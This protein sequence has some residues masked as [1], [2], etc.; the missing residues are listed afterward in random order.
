MR[1]WQPGRYF[2]IFAISPLWIAC[3][4]GGSPTSALESSSSITTEIPTIAT[5]AQ[6]PHYSKLS[7]L[8]ISGICNNGYFVYL[9]GSDFSQQIC[10]NSQYSFTV[11]K[12]VDGIYPYMISQ[13]APGKQASNPALLFW[14]RKNSV[15][16]PTIDSPATNPFQSALSTLALSG[17]CETG[18]TVSL[19]GDAV[20]SVECAN[21]RFDFNVTKFVDQSY[22]IIVRQTDPATN[23]AFINFVWNKMA[24]AS[25]PANPQIVVANSQ[26]FAITGGSGTYAGTFIENNSGGTYDDGTRTY[27]AGTV[28]GVTDR[29]RIEDSLGSA[30]EVTVETVPSTPDH[31][32]IPIDSG[33]GQIHP[34][35]Q[36]LPDPFKAVVVDRYGNPVEN[37]EVVF[38]LMTEGAR[39]VGASNRTTNALG[40]VTVQVRLGESATRIIVL[41]KP[42]TGIFLDEAGTGNTSASFEAFPQFANTNKIGLRSTVGNNPVKVL[43]E[44]LD[45]D[46]FQDFAVLNNGEP[47]LGILR[48]KGNGL[49]HSMVRRQPICTGPTDFTIG[50]LNEDG[51]KDFAI[52]CSGSNRIALILTD[53]DGTYLPA[54]YIDVDPMETLPVAILAFDSNADGHVDLVSLSAGGSVASLRLGVGN[55]SFSAP[56][57][58]N[59]G[60]GPSA[61]TIFDINK[62]GRPDL[63]IVNSSDGTIG[64]LRNTGAGFD[65]METFSTGTA[66][67]S[68][69]AA[70][71]NMDTFDDLAVLNNGDNEIGLYI[72]DQFDNFHPAVNLTVVGGPIGLATTDVNHDSIPDLFVTGTEESKMSI[73]LGFGNGTFDPQPTIDLGPNP[74]GLASADFNGDTHSDFVVIA[75]GDQSAH[76]YIGKGDGTLGFQRATGPNPT[77]AAISDLDGDGV[78]DLAVIE[79]GSNSVSILKGNNTGLW[80]PL[81]TLTTNSGPAA[82]VL[83]DVNNDGF[84]DVVVSHQNVSNV[85]VYLNDG[86]GDFDGSTDYTT[87]LQPIGLS[88]SDLNGDGFVELITA[89]SGSNTVS[90]LQNNGDGTF[91]PR[92]DFPVGSQPVA[93]SVADLNNDLALDLVS[94]NQGSSDVSVLIS[95][96]D[97]TFQVSSQ[98]AVGNGANSIV[99]GFFNGDIDVDVAVVNEMEGSVS[100]LMG[101]GDGSLDN[102]SDFWAGNTP[103]SIRM[104]DFNGDNKQD[105]VVANGGSNSFTVMYGTGSG[106]F[107]LT[108]TILSS[109]A[110]DSLQVGDFN[111]DGSVD[112]VTLEALVGS[113]N[114]WM[115]H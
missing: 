23:T 52:A 20:D 5:P 99:T 71:F 95:N 10:Q 93:I 16:Q 112:I 115:G 34:I 60:L 26:V 65:P 66:P 63:A 53:T 46:G 96:G 77:M 83:A 25:N 101:N 80:Q 1:T 113:M 89:N 55:G 38:S 73:L 103:R 18:S 3:H 105:F 75:N 108:E 92:A 13:A 35:G 40:E 86:T 14:I 32:E 68:I 15:T 21:S 58:F 22:N 8:E 62:D 24:L 31:F 41:A 19:E 90:V 106:F 81:D 82:I 9:N 30:I 91:A 12:N 59:V 42:R 104:G 78:S 85:R 39:I 56:T 2:L 74:I 37:F 48:G 114:F 109:N 6:S 84:V 98:F 100:V 4:M 76:V 27:T 57:F 72:N 36:L 54:S 28:A 7:S 29:I 97:M 79:K 94:V 11:F 51:H 111:G 49:F 47:S 107:S 88:V 102:K 33:S 50:D 44:D 17:G 70:D 87:G 69:V 45:Q 61:L 110:V 43:T 67:V 64:I